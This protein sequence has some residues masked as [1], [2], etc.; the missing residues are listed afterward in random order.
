MLVVDLKKTKLYV[1]NVITIMNMNGATCIYIILK[2][3][4][5]ITPPP[6]TKNNYIKYKR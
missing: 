2:L 3:I 4:E 1:P 6:P 5:T